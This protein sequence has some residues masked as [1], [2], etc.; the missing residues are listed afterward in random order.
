MLA[1]LGCQAA[2]DDSPRSGHAIQVDAES[3][4][5]LESALITM[6][7]YYSGRATPKEVTEAWNCADEALSLFSDFTRGS[8]AHAYSAQELRVFTEVYLLHSS[9]RISDGLLREVMRLKQALLGG[10]IDELSRAEIA[11]AR[12]VFAIL[13]NES[14]RLLPHIRLLKTDVS[15]E[16]V[17]S[18]PRI[19][20]GA[21]TDFLQSLKVVAGLFSRAPEAYRFEN[22]RLLLQEVQNLDVETPEWTWARELSVYISVASAAKTFL[23][24][25]D[26]DQISPGEWPELFSHLGRLYAI[27]LRVHYF[28]ADEP[29][30][31]GDGLVH[32]QAVAKDGL[33]LLEAAIAAKG[34]KRIDHRMI[35]QLIA[36][37]YKAKLIESDVRD[38]TVQG[39]ATVMLEK[40]FNP[41]RVPQ[42]GLT[43]TNY[44]HLK[45][46]LLGW[47]EMQTLW[48]DLL[49][50][51]VTVDSGAG[52]T[53]RV[54]LRLVRDL[55]P[56]LKTS[57]SDP[58]LALKSLFER[59]QP[60][61]F[62]EFDSVSFGSD[63]NRHFI[64]QD[65]F[66]SFNWKQ[67]VIR[68]VLMGYAA[69]Q[70]RMSFVGG[71]EGL[72]AQE[73]EPAFHDARA[74]LI[75]LRSVDPND[76]TIWSSIFFDANLF[77]LA[78]DGD[79]RLSFFEGFDYL[80]YAIA[81]SK[82]NGRNFKI[83]A[84]SCP[85]QGFDVFG[86]P[87]F[88]A[89]CARAGF[90]NR[91]GGFF[92]VLPAWT[93]L[94]KKARGQTAHE[95]QVALENA[96][97]VSGYSEELFEYADLTRMT[98]VL[99]Y[100][101]SIFT[102]FDRDA[103]GI[104]TLPEAMGMYPLLRDLLSEVSG[105]TDEDDLRALFSYILSYGRPPESLMDKVIYKWKQWRE[106]WDCH[107]DRVHLL[108]IIGSLKEA[109][110]QT[111]II[112]DVD[113]DNRV[114]E[115]PASGDDHSEGGDDGPEPELK[116][117]I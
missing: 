84:E 105:F 63:V 73:L 95:L 47:L 5:C 14:L 31:S 35:H 61:S 55:W 20:D 97:R 92:A 37:V 12:Q 43:E 115:A 39:L 68:L 79:E 66:N 81:T 69:D 89:S 107:A 59:P 51:A 24:R 116:P 48:R 88:Q 6:Q 16:R 10:T 38:T 72:S 36:E 42:G 34:D 98:M 25:P 112:D 117:V 80:A 76:V 64:D 108:K 3:Q 21:L 32:M 93:D 102:R 50:R 11:R 96:G 82:L 77:A 83:L 113:D 33:S 44:F 101:E 13:R 109:G 60:V 75:D 70:A 2:L 56:T 52:E 106:N 7:N 28:L 4:H 62:G 46:T 19:I 67:T 65:G 45:R 29:W 74:L 71:V 100:V 85:H 111:A 103:S 27:Y 8:S 26:G 22:F 90:K 18:Q 86:D 17:R 9:L 99:H 104:L 58:Y 87:K 78:S 110:S 23:I 1:L 49:A 114:E 41:S 53:G 91:F 40:I 15:T 57:Y 94:W 30:L 54:P